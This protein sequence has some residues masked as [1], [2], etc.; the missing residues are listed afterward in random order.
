[1]GDTRLKDATQQ[2]LNKRGPKSISRAEVNMP[3]AWNYCEAVQ[4]GNPVYWDEE[5][6]KKTRFGG[7]ICPPQMLKV[8]AGG[9][10]WAPDYIRE[11]DA[12]A[13]KSQGEDY[14][15]KVRVLSDEMGY[16]INTQAGT[17][18][19]FLAPIRPGDGRLI[20]TSMVTEVTDEKQTR[21]GKGVFITSVVEYRTEKDDKLVGRTTMVLLKYK[22]GTPRQT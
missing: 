3:M 4:D 19:E 10:W 21:V 7:L 15:G 11:R 16:T 5:F 8:M 22:P 9:H 2:Y 14:V 12:E 13:I 6:A 17:V 18:G 20:M 1:M